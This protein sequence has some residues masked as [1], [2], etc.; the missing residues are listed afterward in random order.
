[1]LDT[2]TKQQ[3]LDF[4][5]QQPRSVDEVAKHIQK[6]W[7]TADRYITTIA[8]EE[9]TIGTKIFREGSR[10]SLKVVFANTI[11]SAKGTAYQERLLTQILNGKHKEDFS[12]MDIYQFADPTKRTTIKGHLQKQEEDDKNY[13]SLMSQAQTQ[14]FIMSGNLSFIHEIK[15]TQKVLANLASKN[16]KIKILTR[17]DVTSQRTISKLLAINQ[18]YGDDLIQVRHCQQPLR[19]IIVDNTIISLKEIFDP[20]KTKEVQTKQVYYQRINDII[21]ISWLQKVFWKLWEQS[22][23]ANVRLN[24]IKEL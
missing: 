22:V 5:R 19:G 9:G 8:Q 24:A 16:V 2:Q 23:D 20:Q 12:P 21:W 4:V 10:G 1:M 7:R 15:D 13:L 6:N 11:E 3:I 18:Q 14:L 17:L